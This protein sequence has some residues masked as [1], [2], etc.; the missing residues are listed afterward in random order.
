MDFEQRLQSHMNE[1]AN[2]VELPAGEGP[3]AIQQR[4]SGGHQRAITAMTAIA[5]LLMAGAGFLLL[6]D[7]EVPTTSVAAGEAEDAETEDDGDSDENGDGDGNG[8]ANTAI[9]T[10]DV[11]SPNAP[12]YGQVELD[13][14]VY[15]I[16]STAPGKVDTSGNL[17]E[18]DWARISRMNTFYILDENREW[19]TNQIEDRFVS[20]FEIND[21][22]L[23]VLSTGT[24]TT[25]EASFGTS[26]DKGASW[27][28]KSIDSLPDAHQVSLLVTDEA[29]LI[30][31]SRWDSVGYEWAIEQANTAGIELSGET[32]QMLDTEGFSYLPIDPDDP[33]ALTFSYATMSL[34]DFSSYI[35]TV[36][37][38][39]KESLAAE[40]EQTIRYSEE[41][42][43]S[44]GCEFAPDWADPDNLSEPIR[45][46]EVTWAS[47]GV[48]IPE[49]WSAWMRLYS[50]DGTTLNEKYVPFAEQEP[51]WAT[52]IDG[53]L[54][55]TLYEPDEENVEEGGFETRW[56]TRDGENWDSRQ[57]DLN[58]EFA[59]YSPSYLPPNVGEYKFRIWWDESEEEAYAIAVAE[60][61]D[62]IADGELTEEEAMADLGTDYNPE[63]LL[64]RSGSGG[65]WETLD[66]YNLVPGLD[67]GER[68]LSDVRGSSLG[69]M[70]FFVDQSYEDVPLPGTTVLFT[71]NGIDWQQ[72][73]L[74]G[75]SNELYGGDGETLI[76]SKEWILQPGEE[77]GRSQAVLVQPAG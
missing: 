69:V 40:Y 48:D 75:S 74:S 19:Q 6:S 39:E 4:G 46:V 12:A 67:L 47:I 25:D 52:V 45:P 16:L 10:I 54:Q 38:S 41:E 77:L 51:G 33:C 20:D 59:Y 9:T 30:F 50:L 24:F 18:E 21:G 28:W 70:L 27:E 58:D 2:R 11:S 5:V 49:D 8:L 22:V 65:E 34:H 35:E 15:Y 17:S 55:V 76:L 66:P 7:D 53:E 68:R 36:D 26:T 73:E 44:L 57:L 23:Y 61:E 56:T 72:F 42:L 43:E 71:S 29:P 37:E 63:P 64:Q 62:A 32:L 31:A 60:A 3:D 14:G 13:D 1:F